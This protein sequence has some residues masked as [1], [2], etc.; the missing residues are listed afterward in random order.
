[1]QFVQ[2]GVRLR[3]QQGAHAIRMAGEF[4]RLLATHRRWR[5]APGPLPALDQL[6]RAAHAYLKLLRN[7]SARASRLNGLY[8][9]FPQIQ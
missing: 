7:L 1:M 3:R 8:N 2:R 6:D 9:P 4:E 5:H